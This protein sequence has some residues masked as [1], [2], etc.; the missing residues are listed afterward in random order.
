M[1]TAELILPFGQRPE[2]AELPTPTWRV[3]DFLDVQRLP[4]APD[5]KS[6]WSGSGRVRVS[7]LPLEVRVWDLVWE[8]PEA[9]DLELQLCSRDPFRFLT[10]WCRTL[11]Q[12]DQDHPIKLIPGFPY[13]AKVCEAFSPKGAVAGTV[14][15][16]PIHITKHRQA[17]LSWLWAGLFL[18]EFTFS[19]SFSGLFISWKFPKADDGGERS[20]PLSL[21]GKLR[22]MWELLPGWMRA[23]LKFRLGKITHARNPSKFIKAESS[24][25]RA[26]RGDTYR[27]ELLDEAAWIERSEALLEA[28]LLACPE[29]II[30]NSTPNGEQGAHYRIHTTS[31][32]GFIKIE[33]PWTAHPDRSARCTCCPKDSPR[34]CVNRRG[35][36]WEDG[37][38]GRW[39]SPWYDALARKMTEEQVAQELD[40]SYERSASGRI[41]TQFSSQ[42]HLDQTL[43][44][45]S[46]AAL[47]RFWDFGGAVHTV[48]I[49]AQWSGGV[50]EVLES[51]A[52][53][54]AFYDTFCLHVAW[55]RGEL[56][57]ESEIRREEARARKRKGSQ[58]PPVV[59]VKR[60]VIPD[61]E[62]AT[63]HRR[64]GP[65]GRY[66]GRATDIGDP[67][68]EIR[69]PTE[70]GSWYKAL[71][72][73][74][75]LNPGT[76]RAITVGRVY[77]VAS[78]T[79]GVLERITAVRFLLQ[80]RRIR[81]HPERARAVRDALVNHKWPTDKEGKVVPA[82]NP[83]KD[84]HSHPADALGY[85]AG[86][87][88]GGEG[89]Q[90]GGRRMGRRRRR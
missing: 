61:E 22:W 76:D 18:W 71:A 9:R 6:Q 87:L 3:E 36:Y 85:G 7:S 46:E 73:G 43:E 53:A 89:I 86:Y 54:N 2:P 79:P 8:D 25:P 78:P 34:G 81:V 65:P 58:G 48:V 64:W 62:W 16:R 33:I 68:G 50:L 77:M 17:T 31:G 23:P 14:P 15:A 20:T 39:R 26:A 35:L 56:T 59:Q 80:H 74:W 47:F 69:A 66:P 67:A 4:G 57:S 42:L 10:S 38:P 45:R 13:V 84:E 49:W 51:Y 32:T 41:F 44:R 21:V 29:G 1:A 40:L 82:A 12:Y 19:E 55:M 30:L 60:A 5:N 70:E 37:H 52:Q 24:Q 88:V 72:R 28:A 75:T 63:Y 83:V 90:I 11:D 27:R